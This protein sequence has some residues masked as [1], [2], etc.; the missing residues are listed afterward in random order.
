MNEI[1]RRV[2]G[3]V[4]VIAACVA[5]LLTIP[6]LKAQ[7]PTESIGSSSSVPEV[8]EQTLPR[9]WVGVSLN[10]TPL[11]LF[12][13]KTTQNG[14]TGDI[15]ATT[16]ANGQVG[17]GLSVNLR[18]HHYYWLNVGTSY[19]FGGY[20]TNNAINDAAG[21]LYVERT[22]AASSISR[23]W[24]A[25]L[26]LNSAGAATHSMKSAGRSVISPHSTYTRQPS[27]RMAISVA[28]RPASTGSSARPRAS[29]SV[30]EWCSK[31]ISAS[32]RRP[33]SVTPDT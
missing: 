18:L 27:T 16:V 19:Y 22:R 4:G 2:L 1:N 25:T 17:G 31:M 15:L 23:F 14:T 5:A 21:T 13:A 8:R 11:K 29:P 7:D 3:S 20:D 12:S 6:T 10:Y 28:R 30:Q 24:S 33:K 26:V 32:S 9:V